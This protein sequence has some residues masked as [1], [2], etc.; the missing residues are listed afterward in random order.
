MPYP[1]RVPHLSE[2]G[3]I[4]NRNIYLWHS[5]PVWPQPLPLGWPSAQALEQY[6]LP[7]FSMAS[8]RLTTHKQ[9][10]QAHFIWVM[11]VIWDSPDKLVFLYIHLNIY[12][13]VCQGNVKT[14]LQKMDRS[15]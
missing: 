9:E 1:V 7:L 2:K 5:Q 10:G 14:L 12:S 15:R 11:V 6:D 4:L 13:D 3:Y 8:V